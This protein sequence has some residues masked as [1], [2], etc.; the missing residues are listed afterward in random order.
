G[1]GSRIAIPVRAQNCT[2]LQCFDLATYLKMHDRNVLAVKRCGKKL[3]GVDAS[4]DKKHVSWDCPICKGKAEV[5]DLHIDGY[6]ESLLQGYRDLQKVVEVKI[7]SDGS[8]HPIV[9]P[10]V[11]V[12]PVSDSPVIRADPEETEKQVDE[13]PLEAHHPANHSDN[14]D[15]E[16]MSADDMEIT[17]MSLEE[18]RRLPETHQLCKAVKRRLLDKLKTMKK[19]KAMEG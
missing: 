5:R 1:R 6:F 16:E 11:E 3:L 4:V 18:I 10:K 12:I 7:M 13:K 8:H 2:H 9:E 17:D 19:K 14:A 15:E